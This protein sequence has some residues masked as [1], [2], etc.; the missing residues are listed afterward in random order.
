MIEWFSTELGWWG[1]GAE[2]RGDVRRVWVYD[3]ITVHLKIPEC[4]IGRKEQL[5]E[6][7]SAARTV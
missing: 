1:M 4:L 3:L 2:G 7:K 6:C 5:T